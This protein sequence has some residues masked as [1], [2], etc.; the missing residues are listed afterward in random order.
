MSKRKITKKEITWVKTLI[1]GGLGW[2]FIV[3][4]L[5]SLLDGFLPDG[6]FRIIIGI[7]AIL[8]VLYFWE[9]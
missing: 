7:L 8:G 2:M 5:T 9:I 1:V 4:P 6:N 3:K